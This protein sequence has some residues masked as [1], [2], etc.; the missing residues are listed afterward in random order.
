M[1]HAMEL[2]IGGRLLRLASCRRGGA[3]KIAQPLMEASTHDLETE[4]TTIASRRQWR[5]IDPETSGPRELGICCPDSIRMGASTGR[6][7]ADRT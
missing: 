7:P 5:T 6:A 3:M 1:A 2:R 4:S